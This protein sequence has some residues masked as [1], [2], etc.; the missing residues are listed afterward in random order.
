MAVTLIGT[1]LMSSERFWE[2]TTTGAS[3]LLLPASA[4]GVSAPATVA[5]ATTRGAAEAVAGGLACGMDAV[6]GALCPGAASFG[7]A[8]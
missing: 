8:A 5:W 2:V 1:D 6:A 3:T 4:G 7:S